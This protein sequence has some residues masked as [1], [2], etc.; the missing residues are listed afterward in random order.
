MTRILIVDDEKKMRTLL[1]MMLVKEGFT[2]DL[3]DNGLS[4]LALMGEKQYDL[5][6][7]DIKMPRM[8]GGQM[9]ATMR[10]KDIAT[11]VICITA[12]ATIDSAVEIMQK[13]ACDYITKP[14]DTGKILLAVKK[15]LSLSRLIRENQDMKQMIN[16]Q[17]HEMIYQSANMQQVVDLALNV[18]SV[19]TAVLIL[20]E[21]GTGKEVV[22]NFIHRNSPRAGNRFVAVNC[23]A[24]SSNLVESELF[25]YEKGAFTGAARQTRGKFEFADQG[26]LFL[27]EIGDLPLESQGKLLRALQEKKFQR[28]GGNEEI[29]VDVRVICATNQ[30]LDQMVLDKKFRQ[31]LFYRINVFPIVIPP[32][33]ER[34][35]DIVPLARYIMSTFSFG[36]NHELTDD[37]CRKLVEYP[38]P[39]NVRELSN[40]LERCVI[41][42]R[43][44]GRITS[45]TLSFLQVPGT[46]Q[47]RGSKLVIRLPATG[48]S[49]SKVQMALVRQALEAAGNNQTNAA[50]LLGLSRAKFRV[51][52]KNM[53]EDKGQD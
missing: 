2:T 28:V 12:F 27:D 1:S 52:L 44:S 13:G 33:R 32:L 25:G 35:D 29:P 18:A 53:N 50:K 19:D 46:S 30:N 22:A 47:E 45:D 21:S 5:V 34:R 8:D 49:L 48:I 51:L 6:I 39:G 14:F 9:I 4:A 31:D 16:S 7:S 10:E 40:V 11:P 3:A 36:R 23:A 42:T 24:I 38:W 20:G 43:D 15:A 17:G 37:A 26:S 41:L